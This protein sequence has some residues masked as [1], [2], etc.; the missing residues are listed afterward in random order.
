MVTSNKS[1]KN[2]DIEAIYPLS[3]TQEGMLFHTL[4][5][6]DSNL[7]FDQFCLKIQ[8][9]LDII[10]FQEG[11]QTILDRHPILRTVFIWKNRKTPLQIV[12]KQVK[13][14]WINHD[15]RNLSQQDQESCLKVFLEADRKQGVNTDK[16][17]L[18][19]CNL[20]QINDNT[21]QLIWSFH[22]LLCDGWSWPIIFQ[23]IFIIYQA[24]KQGKSDNLASPRPY[25]DYINWLQKQNKSL[26]ETFWRKTLKGFTIPTPLREDK[27]DKKTDKTYNILR[28]NL[29]ASLTSQ[30]KSFATQNHLTLSTLVQAAWALLL[31]RYSGEKDI[32]F[33]TVV[34]GRTSTL[35]GIESIVGLF[36]N[37]L[38]TRIKI[39]KETKILPWLSQIQEQHIESEQYSYSSLVD[40]KGWSDISR[41][42]SLFE[43]ILAFENYPA[44]AIAENLPDG[45]KIIEMEDIGQTNYPLVVRAIPFSEM[46][47]MINYEENSFD[48]TTIDRM[49]CH[50]QTLLEEI[51]IN[52]DRCHK[53]VSILTKAER[54]MILNEWNNTLS[55]SPI[56]QCVHQLFEKQVS[57]NPNAVAVV[58]KNELLTYQQLN[59]KANQLAHYLHYLGVKPDSFVAICLDRSLDIAIAIL[60]IL[61]AGGACVPI[62]PKYPEERIN[63]ILENSKTDIVL[64]Q[65]SF[66]SMLSKDLVKHLIILED[67]WEEISQESCQN[68]TIEINHHH[69]AYLIYTSGS[70]GIPKGVA[71]PHRSLTNL[72]EH[73]RDKML[74]GCKV[75]QFASFSFDV[76]YHEMVAA[77]CF[78][79]TLYIASEETRLDLDKLVKLLADNSIEK[80]ILPVTLWQ[81]I[82]EL[83]GDKIHLFKNLKEAIAA[84]EQLQITP[85]MI[86]LFKQLDNCRFYNFYGP[87]EADLVTVYAFDIY[88]EKWPFYPPIGKPAVNVKVYLLNEDLQPVPL[89]S[90]GELYVSGSGLARGYFNR[91]ELTTEKFIPNPFCQDNQFD[92]YLYKTGDLARYLPDGNIEFI[93]RMDD[94]VK[95]RGY[96][97]E[98]GELEAV[99]N[100]HPGLS[101]ATVKVY[102][103]KAT[104]K[105]LCAYFVPLKTETITIEAL[106][107]FL[108]KQLP[109]YMIPS[110][111]M[112]MEYL[113]LTSNGKVDRRKLPEPTT[114]RPE[115]IQKYVAPNTPTEEILTAIWQDILGLTK[116]GINDNFFSLGGH[117][118]LVTQVMA[119]I[120]KT[121][122]IE[123]PIRSLFDSPTIASLAQNIEKQNNNKISEPIIAISRQL[124]NNQLIPI[125][126]TQFELWFFDQFYP[127]N[128]VYNLPLVYQIQGK[129]N[130]SILEKS[131]KEIVKRH[132]ILRTNFIYKDGQVFQRIPLETETSLDFSIVNL[133]LLSQEEQEQVSQQ[134]L[135][136]EMAQSFDLE[137]G[138]L[139][140][141]KVFQLSNDDYLFIVTMHHIVSDGLSF[142]IFIRE[143]S[144]I[145]E[146]FSKDQPSSLPDL[147]IQYAD[148]SL[149]QWQSRNQ[150]FWESHLNFWKQYIGVNPPILNLPTDYPRTE[151]RTFKGATYPVTISLELTRALK[152]VSQQEQATL[153][154]TLLS[155]FQTLLFYYTQ[156]EDIIVGG[157][158]ANRNRAEIQDLI[159]FFVNLFPIYANFGGNPSF[160]DLLRQIREATLEIYAHQEIPFIELIEHLKPIR[161]SRYLLLT[162]VMFLFH[163]SSKPD[164]KLANLTLKEQFFET[165]I[166]QEDTAEFDLTMSLEETDEGVKGYLVYKS[167]LFAQKTIIKMSNYFQELLKNIVANPD[168]KIAD[169][170]S[171]YEQ[172][173][174]ALNSLASSRQNIETI[175]V[176]EPRNFTEQML[177]DIWKEVL[178]LEQVG[179]KQNFFELGGTSQKLLQIMNKLNQKMQ[180]NIPLHYFFEQ[181]TIADLAKIL[182]L[183]D[184]I[185]SNFY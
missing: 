145:Y 25:Q 120:R 102:G 47:L 146:A 26:A 113:P 154:M 109:E 177:V 96:S 176:I 131:L 129:L 128:S 137:K 4:Y 156:Q 81:Q 3:P 123:L 151:K 58:Y 51:V 86:A 152:I 130:I 62:D 44:T 142:G 90:T 138:S 180:K 118:L 107:S 97:V 85:P 53:D 135:S 149:W 17:P 34:S 174:M 122:N 106:R 124:G 21:Y 165:N 70:T 160:R 178:E 164:L 5:N 33:G 36:I 139:F 89:G 126:L 39:P 2:K 78:G 161:D 94:R 22:H 46:A 101:Q 168:Q 115:L 182:L 32:V 84:G 52:P 65:E 18:M 183:T 66:Q 20:I 157:I 6:P 16:A 8:G 10:A 43:T 133:E 153:Y 103:K 185:D 29:S 30:L 172:T 171:F 95:I 41:D 75:L 57:Q 1:H 83:Y 45:L 79:G 173:S 7:Y 31:S 169:L 150:Q 104:D 67:Q 11:W 93:G 162:Q 73:H 110:V 68:L 136:E 147:P 19:R 50:L 117:S 87:S 64:T 144:V 114:N 143:L 184:S 61:K 49:L 59:E 163:N 170:F 71:V 88:P 91:P 63:F 100:Q 112:S 74:T 175:N 15:W 56:T 54:Q 40:I 159:G 35:S 181:P 119:L 13:L 158:I 72:V 127:E 125:S 28:K 14:P 69:L 48:A 27:L 116:I 141:S 140:R 24:I 134:L 82:A 99:L 98:L 80:A 77:W 166:E 9:E 42:E 38:P 111:F 105:Y 55:L 167:D 155:A 12:R 60:G 23:E 179:I 121:F 37:T 132:Q 148:F 92:F 76:S 108:E